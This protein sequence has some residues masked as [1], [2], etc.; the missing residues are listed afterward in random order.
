MGRAFAG[1]TSMRSV[2]FAHYLTAETSRLTPT[3]FVEKADFQLFGVSLTLWDC[4]GQD[5][6]MENYY[7]AHKE[8]IFKN[9]KVTRQL[10]NRL[11]PQILV[12]VMEVR[13]AE[14]ALITDEDVA[15][16]GFEGVRSKKLARDL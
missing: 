13:T 12:Y 14:I 6:F 3:T 1:K 9:V 11:K 2:I 4:G 8:A 15:K 7:H 16:R 5:S 10:Q